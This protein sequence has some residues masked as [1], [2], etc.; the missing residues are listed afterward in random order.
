VWLVNGL[1]LVINQKKYFTI[2]SEVGSC[3]EGFDVSSGETSNSVFTNIASHIKTLGITIFTT[4][5]TTTTT[6]TANQQPTNSQ[7]TVT[8]SN[9]QPATSSNK[10]Q[11]PTKQIKVVTTTTI[12]HNDVQQPKP[13]LQLTN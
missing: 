6:T 5:T 8:N 7:P 11:Q 12:A 2:H 9:Q 3:Q 10:Q 13:T 4:T 1:Y